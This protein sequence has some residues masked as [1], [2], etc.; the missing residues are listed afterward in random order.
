M[1]QT[2]FN[3]SPCGYWKVFYRVAYMMWCDTPPDDEDDFTCTSYV[4]CVLC[5]ADASV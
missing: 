1:A 2:L 4:S 5:F 3:Q